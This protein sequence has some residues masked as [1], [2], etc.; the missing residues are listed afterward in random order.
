M[1][2][3]RINQNEEHIP[4][5]VG[6]TSLVEQEIKATTYEGILQ[7]PVPK[8]EEDGSELEDF[9]LCDFCDLIMANYMAFVVVARQTK[10]KTIFERE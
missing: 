2:M 7:C 5:K 10:A 9:Y 8:E 3:Q 6:L 1:K 4:E